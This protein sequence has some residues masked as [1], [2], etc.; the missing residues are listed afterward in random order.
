VEQ[1][2]SFLFFSSAAD[3]LV[4][5]TVS[6]NADAKL[7]DMY[8]MTYAEWHGDKIEPYTIGKL[9]VCPPWES[10]V[11]DEK[12]K[13]NKLILDPG[14]VFGTG[15]HTTT[16]DCLSMLNKLLQK[17]D[18]SSVMDIGSGTGLL[19]AGAAILGAKKVL[20][21]DFNFLAAKT[22]LHNARL[23][24]LESSML[25]AQARGEEFVDLHAD[26][27]VANI[28]YD[29]MKDIIDEKGF[30]KKKWFILSGLLRTQA[31]I[32][33]SNLAEKPV[34]IIEHRCPDGIWNTILGK[35]DLY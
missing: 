3:E 29:V 4:K 6:C 10:I 17:E 26:I 28:H 30:L 22:T 7:I 11:Q 20:A 33:L 31:K 8:E 23:N 5:A 9:L 14:V 1:D 15:K 18:I 12:N 32:I 19:S 25:V 21:C 13:F 27:V 24:F 35:S 16:E 34:T 2:S